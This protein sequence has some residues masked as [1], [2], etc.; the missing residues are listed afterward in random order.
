MWVSYSKRPLRAEELCHALGVEIG[1]PDLD[2]NN[3][4][5]L[6]ILQSSCLGLVTIEA[7]SSI[8]RLLHFTLQDHFL[9]NPILFHSPHATIAKV[10]LTYLNSES[11]RD[12]SPTLPSVP[13]TM[14][15]LEYASL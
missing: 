4:P 12:L 10:C 7:S 15:L 5:D 1:S 9:S 11:V 14:P 3:A 8:V 6:R 13:S 2:P